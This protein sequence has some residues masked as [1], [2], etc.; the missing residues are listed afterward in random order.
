MTT[1][2]KK[3]RAKTLKGGSV[4]VARESLD[5][6]LR[7][8]SGPLPVSEEFQ[9]KI[10]FTRLLDAG[11]TFRTG[12]VFVQIRRPDK[13]SHMVDATG[14]DCHAWRFTAI[15]PHMKVWAALGRTAGI[16]ELVSWFENREP[17]K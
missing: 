4:V 7:E 10:W 6:L 1:T 16:V 9:R 15:C 17:M 3:P 11:W 8:F 13:E 12:G 14:C 5:W 2:A